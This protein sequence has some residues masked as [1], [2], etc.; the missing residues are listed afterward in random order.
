MLVVNVKAIVNAVTIDPASIINVLIR[1]S[2]NAVPVQHAKQ[3]DIWLSVNVLMVPT[4]M[5]WFHVV[6]R[7]RIR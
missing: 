7:E 5:P 3:N 6:N 1:V 4:V 2:V